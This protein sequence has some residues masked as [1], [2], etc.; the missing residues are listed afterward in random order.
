M[1]SETGYSVIFLKIVSVDDNVCDSLVS[2][3][4]TTWAIHVKE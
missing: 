2:W 4:L 1:N 3:F